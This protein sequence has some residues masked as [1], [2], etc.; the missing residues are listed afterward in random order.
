[1]HISHTHLHL[2]RSVPLVLCA[3]GLLLLGLGGLPPLGGP[4]ALGLLALAVRRVLLLLKVAPLAPLN[5]AP[6]APRGK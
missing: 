5:G 1:M 6:A 3:V 4:A 2:V